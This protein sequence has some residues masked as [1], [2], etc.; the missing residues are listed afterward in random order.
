MKVKT[1]AREA[2]KDRLA[3]LAELAAYD[4]KIGI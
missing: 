1:E 2:R 4:Q 3:A